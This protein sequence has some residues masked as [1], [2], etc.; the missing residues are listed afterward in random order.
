M[1][2]LNQANNLMSGEIEVQKVY[3]REVLVWER[4]RYDITKIAVVE[5][6]GNFQPTEQVEYFEKISATKNFLKANP[7]KFY[8]VFIGEN[9]N[10][11]SISN[12][13][14]QDIINLVEITIPESVTT[15]GRDAFHGC[16]GLKTAELNCPITKIDMYTFDN[17]IN[18]ENITLPETLTDISIHAFY[19][20]TN[21]KEITFP[22]NLA[23]IGNNA[24]QNSGLLHV[25]CHVPELTLGMNVF[26]SSALVSVSVGHVVSADKGVF[27]KCN[28]LVSVEFSGVSISN[29]MFSECASLETVH[30]GAEIQEISS[31]A[32]NN[33]PSLTAIYLDVPENSV[34]GANW[35][36]P[37]TCKVHW[38]D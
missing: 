37:D 25:D 11:T 20:C 17:C 31:T 26:V 27:S 28:S 13:A 1:S 29:T 9:A 15:I 35:G 5:L 24:F 18:L 2:I 4:K 14:F 36:A 34:S 6:D 23:V 16:K 38:L 19:Q 30:I 22:K 12:Y 7:E 3:S 8:A 32:F 10:I 21:L 33:T